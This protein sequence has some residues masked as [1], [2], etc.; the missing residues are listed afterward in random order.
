MKVKKGANDET[1]ELAKLQKSN[2]RLNVE[3]GSLKF[4][5]MKG[6]E[7]FKKELRKKDEDAREVVEERDSTKI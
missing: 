1:S 4:D 2:H 7:E 6:Q 3:I 5:L